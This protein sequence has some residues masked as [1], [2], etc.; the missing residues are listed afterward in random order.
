MILVISDTHARG[1]E[2]LPK[3]LI[4]RMERADLIIHA[5]DF[6][7]YD[8]YSELRSTA[9]L[10]AVAGNSDEYEIT[11]ELPETARIDVEGIGIGV[12]H[13]PIFDD[14]SDLVYKAKELEVDLMVFGHTHRPH[15]RVVGGVILLN[16]GSP[17]LPRFRIP[18]FAEVYVGED[19]EVTVRGVGGEVVARLEFSRG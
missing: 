1:M 10:E 11:L 8:F 17:T 3:T 4:E 14:F 12:T 6:D 2:D 7:T 15:L 5:G 16:P 9:K 19:I 13:M 18:T